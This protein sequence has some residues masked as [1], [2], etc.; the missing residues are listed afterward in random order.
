MDVSGNLPDDDYST[1][2]LVSKDVSG[3]TSG[4]RKLPPI[5]TVNETKPDNALSESKRK[6]PKAQLDRRK[7]INSEHDGPR[8]RSLSLIVDRRKSV[9]VNG[10]SSFNNSPTLGHSVKYNRIS[11]VSDESA[12]NDSVSA[13]SDRGT[14]GNL[15]NILTS[16][17]L[18]VRLKY[19]V[20]TSKM[21]VF[22]IKA[23]FE[24]TKKL[25]KQ[26]LVQIHLTVLPNKRIR[27]RTRSKQWEDTMFAE[28]FFC[29]VSPEIM[30]TQGIR[31]R[32]YMNE[33]L[34]RQHLLGEATV[35]FGLINLE[36]D[37][38]KL[39]T[40]E[41]KSMLYIPKESDSGTGIHTT[42]SVLSSR[43]NSSSITQS[44]IPEIELGLAYDRIQSHLIVE[45]GKGFNFGVATQ[46]RAPDTC[47]KI[48]LLNITG[49]EIISN[50]T[51]LRRSQYHPVYAERYS[52]NIQESLLDTITLLITILNKKNIRKSE[53]LGWIAFGQGVNGDLQIAHWDSMRNANGETITR[54][55]I[56]LES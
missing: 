37:M 10:R 43:R 52:F 34:K 14:A 56:L 22:V 50:R 35:M 45:M 7:I 46:G 36:E 9:S 33:R 6:N 41:P 23:N 51:V 2:Q 44:Q 53:P 38:C 29:K 21:W 8:R 48:S 49:E 16:G 47:A 19:D 13:S 18:E 42:D 15:N 54:R 17:T 4:G 20:K 30:Q 25:S 11:R 1:E 26:T 31:F 55:H 39:I 24:T 3:G 28:E 12:D 32:L 27:F 5:P 40:F